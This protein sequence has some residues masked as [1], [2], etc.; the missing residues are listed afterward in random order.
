M[1]DNLSC[2]LLIDDDYTVNFL[3]ENIINSAKITRSLE[4]AETGEKGLELLKD[5]IK[6]KHEKID[7]V[8]LD[9]NMPKM[10]GWRFIEEY[11]KIQNPNQRPVILILSSSANPDDQLRAEK[12]NEVAGF[13]HKPLTSD[14]LKNIV[15]KHFRNA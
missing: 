10:D 12:T 14:V 7:L 4:I 11:K 13:Y 15:R 9:L 3:H 1:K 5:S 8:F 6:G 2:I